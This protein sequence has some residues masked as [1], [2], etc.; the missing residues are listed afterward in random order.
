MDFRAKEKSLYF[1]EK[2]YQTLEIVEEESYLS[3]YINGLIQWNSSDEKLYHESLVIP[4]INYLSKIKKDLKILVLG[5]GD[6]FVIRELKK[7]D[8]FIKD[9]TL[10][11]IDSTVIDIHR[12]LPYLKLINE[13][14]FEY[15]KLNIIIEDAVKFIDETEEKY[16]LI[17]SDLVD[18]E[19]SLSFLYSTKFFNNL[20]RINNGLL[21]YQAG[22]SLFNREQNEKLHKNAKK[23]LKKYFNSYIS[24]PYF[25]YYNFI[26]FSNEKNFEY[27]SIYKTKIPKKIY[28][29]NEFILNKNILKSLFY[30]KDIYNK[31]NKVIKRM[32]K[33]GK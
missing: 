23:T 17:I 28:Q 2:E 15:E 21:V 7:Y 26:V 24:I 14:S 30:F 4:Y 27:K 5:G 1:I 3:F 19:D 29:Q 25:G 10:V 20:K 16:D 11:D 9:I 33:D 18:P 31:N 22:D 32:Q 6:G 13:N 8:E 12:E